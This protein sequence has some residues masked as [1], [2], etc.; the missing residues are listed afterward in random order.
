MREKKFR[1]KKRWLRCIYK[2]KIDGEA[3]FC[4]GYVPLTDGEREPALAPMYIY[5]FTF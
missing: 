3:H 5:N 4:G 1:E 2:E